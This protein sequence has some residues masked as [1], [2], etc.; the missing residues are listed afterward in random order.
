VIEKIL[1]QHKHFGNARYLMQMTVG[2]V[3]H[4]KLLRSIELFATKVAPAVR[5]ATAQKKNGAH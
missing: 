4:D 1:A 5:A 3:P 2:A